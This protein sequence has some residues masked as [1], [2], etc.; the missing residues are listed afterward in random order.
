MLVFFLCIVQLNLPI[1]LSLIYPQ[2]FFDGPAKV[3]SKWKMTFD[4]DLSFEIMIQS[5]EGAN[6]HEEFELPCPEMSGLDDNRVD[7][8]IV[9]LMP[10]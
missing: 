6:P 5:A 7:S 4:L 9:S 1:P 3:A 8:A 2:W 10:V